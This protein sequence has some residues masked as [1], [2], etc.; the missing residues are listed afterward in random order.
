MDY[1]HCI[2][3]DVLLELALHCSPSLLLTILRTSP[4]MAVLCRMGCLWDRYINACTA[5]H[6]QD[7]HTLLLPLASD[8]DQIASLLIIADVY[9]NWQT[10]QIIQL[11][12]RLSIAGKMAVL[13]TLLDRNGKSLAARLARWE[14]F[15]DLLEHRRPGLCV[16]Q[17]CI[18][19]LLRRAAKD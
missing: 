2:P 16:Y 19:P 15:Q 10:K 3:V 8:A 12:S 5:M 7:M 18:A 17:K 13:R 4:R 14:S 11:W 9:A 1:L 6:M